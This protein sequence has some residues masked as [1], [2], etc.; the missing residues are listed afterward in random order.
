MSCLVVVLSFLCAW[1]SVAGELTLKNGDRLQGEL[2]KVDSKKLTWKSTSFGD[3]SINKTQVK[4]I[5]IEQAVKIEGQVDTCYLAGLNDEDMV[6]QCG[7]NLMQAPFASINSVY[8]YVEYQAGAYTYAGS[9][10][11]AVDFKR[12]NEIKDDIDFNSS[13]NFRRGD[14]RHITVIDYESISSNDQAPNV[15]AEFSYRLDWFFHERWFWYNQLTYNEDEPRLVEESYTL[16]SGLGVQIWDYSHVSLSIDS[17]FEFESQNFEP[18]DEDELNPD[19]QSTS[20]KEFWRLGYDFMYK[21]PWSINLINSAEILL[22]MD[23]T[24]DWVL[25]MDLGLSVPLGGSL[26]SE[27]KLEYDFDNLPNGDKKQ[28]DTKF[29]VGVGYKW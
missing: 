1:V 21:L 13:V 25:E 9:M 28:D 7:G 2:V 23:E 20:H 29:T 6:Y 19:W 12:G 15:K 24:E 11:I 3:L 5:D 27:Y 14:W 22:N 8:P 16:G 18:S 4:G 17:G 26:S 10:H